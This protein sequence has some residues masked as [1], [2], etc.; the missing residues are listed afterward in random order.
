MRSPL[1]AKRAD[2]IDLAGLIDM[3]IHSA[4]DVRPRPLDDL[5]AAQS[6][7]EAGMRAILLKSHVTLTADRAA[8][9]DKIVPGI[10]V[11]GGLVLNHE[12][13]G[14]NPAA[15]EAAL[16]MGA[17]QIWMPTTSAAQDM[18][19]YR[20]LRPERPAPKRAGI[21]LLREDGSLVPSV[22]EILALVAEAEI[23]ISSAHLSPAEVTVFVKAAR[24]HGI[25]RILVTHPE[26][27]LSEIPLALQED[28]AQPGVWFEHCYV[29]TLLE[30]EK[31]PLASIAA[32][33]RAV[34]PEHAV[35]TTD[36]GNPAFSPPVDGMRSYLSGL[37]ALGISWGDL[38]MMTRDN[39]AYLLGLGE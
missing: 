6:A 23:I 22:H 15:V 13:G 29:N 18:A 26:A 7:R 17:R 33:I 24:E 38:V 11:F 28:L 34:G 32:R 5:Q 31:I 8:I 37:I 20:K 25:R 3:H 10:R 12:V 36:L 4:P 27:A 30:G 2:D 21:T 35:L 9:A 39:P 14:L 1:V 16:R 19:F